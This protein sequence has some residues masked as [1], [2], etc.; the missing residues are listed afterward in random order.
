VFA[1]SNLDGFIQ[2]VN[3]QRGKKIDAV[4][5]DL[6]VAG[7]QTFDQGSF[8]TYS[9]AFPRQPRTRRFPG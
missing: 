9:R 1:K 3:A 8:S 7:P 4:Y 6:L 5:A 2:L